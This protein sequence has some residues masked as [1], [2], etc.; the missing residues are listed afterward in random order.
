MP[1]LS[2]MSPMSASSVSKRL[3]TWLGLTLFFTLFGLGIAGRTDLSM[4]NAFLVMCSLL[5][6]GAAWTIDANLAAK[7]LQPGQKGED[8]GRLLLI[9]GSV[10]LTFVLALLDV[11]RFH[12]SDTV[13]RSLQVVALA[14]SALS[15]GWSLWAVR[16]NRFFI[17]TIRIQSERGHQ[18]VR[19]GPY[20]YV[21]HPGYLGLVVGAPAF[22]LALGSWWALIPALAVSILFSRRAA[23][24]DRF[25]LGHLEGYSDY[26]HH[27]RHRLVPGVW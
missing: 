12:W 15:L 6:L 26:A 8:P 19:G 27:V 23:H 7:R 11:G 13:P 4:V 3:L 2:A 1:I 22:A 10:L 5:A 9:R 16:A 18:V 17:P 20:A 21:R 24:E 14:V 25:L